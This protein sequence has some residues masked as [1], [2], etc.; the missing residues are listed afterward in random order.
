MTRRMRVARAIAARVAA[1]LIGFILLVYGLVATLSPL[2]AGAPLVV[3]GALIIA[4][5]N[6]GARP[7]IRRLRRR[8]RWFDILVRRVAKTGPAPIKAVEAETSSPAAEPK[9]P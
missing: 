7:F 2:P 4:A 9:V 6:P 8:W 1:S 5:A 3:F